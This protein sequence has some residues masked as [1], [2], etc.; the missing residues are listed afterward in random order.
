MICSTRLR[1]ANRRPELK[2]LP[3]RPNAPVEARA[4]LKKQ[5]IAKPMAQA[6][7]LSWPPPNEQVPGWTM[8]MMRFPPRPDGPVTVS[9]PGAR[10]PHIFCPLA[11]DPQ[12]RH[13]RSGEVGALFGK[14]H[15]EKTQE[16]V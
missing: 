10:A 2:D 11:V 14:Q 5:R 15:G 13:S 6:S 3:A 7:M 12:P 16:L 4:A 1:E 8:L 9:I